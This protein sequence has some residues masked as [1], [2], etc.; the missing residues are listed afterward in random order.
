MNSDTSEPSPNLVP[1]RIQK[2][3]RKNYD[4]YPFVDMD[5]KHCAIITKN[6]KIISEGFNNMKSHPF[7]M[8]PLGCL[9]KPEIDY[10]DLRTLHAEMKAV[11]NIKD[12]NRLKG[13][14]IFVFSMNRKGQLRISRPCD[15]CMYYLKM[16]GIS[17][18][19]YTI[20][21][22]WEKEKI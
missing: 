1:I 6:G 17:K 16:Y 20:N 10:R 22:K 18:I 4:S 21:G 15:L 7:A 11:K 14:S 3:I 8:R 12:K 2:K 19:Y 5:Y 9:H 13:A